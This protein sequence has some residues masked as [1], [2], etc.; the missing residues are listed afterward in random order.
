M[1]PARCDELDSLHFLVAAQRVFGNVET[2]KSHP[3]AAGD[4][5]AHDAYTRLLLRCQSDGMTLWAEVQ[6]CVVQRRGSLALDGTTLDESYARVLRSS[7]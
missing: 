6:P 2:A 1:N 7:V 3:T 4:R 5:P